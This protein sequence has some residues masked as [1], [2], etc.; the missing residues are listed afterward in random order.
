MSV[1][2]IPDFG[3]SPAFDAARD[4]RHQSPPPALPDEFAE[5]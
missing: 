2:K 4:V 3:Q 5:K 1:R